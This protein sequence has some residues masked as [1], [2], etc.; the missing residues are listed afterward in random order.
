MIAVLLGLMTLTLGGTE[1]EGART[2]EPKRVSRLLERIDAYN[3]LLQHGRYDDS[4]EMLS[5]WWVEDPDDRREWNRAARR[6]DNG[7]K[8]LGW[9]VKQVWIAGNRAKVRMATRG[10]T[11]ETRSRWSEYVH[12]EDH[13]WMF[14]NNDWYYIPLK[15]RDWDDSEAVEVTVP[16]EPLGVDIKQKD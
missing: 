8:I 12:D 16:N 6:M 11:R 5:Q 4:Y 1:D 14:E 13:F 10:K 9:E 3:N 15:I 7:I 2:A